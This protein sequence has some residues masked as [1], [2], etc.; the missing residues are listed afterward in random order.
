MSK[1]L[2]SILGTCTI[3]GVIVAILLILLGATV[4]GFSLFSHTAKF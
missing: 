2:Q 3:G 1:K 4:A